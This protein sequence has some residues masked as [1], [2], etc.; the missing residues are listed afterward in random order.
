MSIA[1]KLIQITENLKK[2]YDKGFQD[3]SKG[4]NSDGNYSDGY[5]QGYS[6]GWD[7]GYWAGYDDAWNEINGGGEEEGV[8]YSCHNCGTSFRTEGPPICPECGVN[9]DEWYEG[10]PSFTCP[11]CGKV[12]YTEGPPIC[13]H[14]GTDADQ[15]YEENGGQSHPEGA[16]QNCGSE[17][18]SS[19]N[20]LIDGSN[21]EI[22][23]DCGARKCPDCG[24][25]VITEGP[26]VCDCGKELWLEGE[27]E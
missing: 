26:W 21:I 13:P 14:C 23:A 18:S 5:N 4:S 25:W 10:M 12:V 11:N 22:C 27:N 20:Y 6:E 17:T 15:W 8:E 19:D 1:D 7:S 24:T 2:I 3:G 16:C 9:Q